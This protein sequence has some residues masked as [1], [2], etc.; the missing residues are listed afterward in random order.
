MSFVSE[1]APALTW[2]SDGE[3]R[4]GL[5]TDAEHVERLSGGLGL[6]SACCLV[7]DQS[8]MCGLPSLLKP[9]RPWDAFPDKDLALN[10]EHIFQLN[11]ES[12][13]S[14]G[15]LLSREWTLNLLL[16]GHVWLFNLQ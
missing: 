11:T 5:C 10:S 3:C 13:L 14:G 16:D 4:P 12:C 15:W 9:G 2:W 1:Q 8:F 7:S 6:V